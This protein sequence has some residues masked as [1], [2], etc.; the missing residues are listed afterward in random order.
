MKRVALLFIGIF[1]AVAVWG[2][3]SSRAAQKETLRITCWEGYADATVVK[4]FKELI[5]KKYGIGSGK[6]TAL[7][8]QAALE[9]ELADGS[10]RYTGFL[11]AHCF[12]FKVL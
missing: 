1:I 11:F 9:Q 8:R 2:T 5:M 4:E 12:H 10:I 7:Q 6:A 3:N